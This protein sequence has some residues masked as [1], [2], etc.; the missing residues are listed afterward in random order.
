M[1]ANKLRKRSIFI[2]YSIALVGVNLFT[3]CSGKKEAPKQEIAKVWESN[4]EVM[5]YDFES[6][7]TGNGIEKVKSEYTIVPNGAS[8][9]MELSFY[10]DEKISGI[11]IKPNDSL[12]LDPNK[13]YSL[14]FDAKSLGGK[15][16]FIAVRMANEKGN[17]IRKIVNIHPDALKSYYLEFTVQEQDVASG[18]RDTPKAWK[19]DAIQMKVSGLLYKTSYTKVASIEIYKEQGLHDKKIL[20]DNI[21]IMESPDRD[22]NFLKG[23]VDKYGQNAKMD[24]PIKVSSDE[25]LKR[26]ADE[27]LKSLAEYTLMPDRSQYGG[28]KNGPK[29]KATGFFRKEKVN[30]KW[31]LVDPEGNL[32][33]SIG[34]ANVRMA[35]STTF[36]GIDYTDDSIKH[37]DPEDV[38]PEDSKGIVAIPNAIRKTG[39]VSNKLRNDMFIGL[40]SYDDPLANHYSYR[41]E[42][43]FGP[44][45]HGETFSFYRANLE[46]RYGEQYPNSF[47]DKWLEVTENRM[48]NW[49]FTSFG[50][51]IDPAF[52]DR[53]NLPY[54]ANGWIIGDFQKVYSGVDY[55]GPMPD[56][57]DPEFERRAKKSIDVVS[58]EVKNNP[59][60]I[61]VFVDNERSWGSPSSHRTHYGLV[62][63][64][65]SKDKNSYLK[66]EFMKILRKKHKTIASLNTAWETNIESWEALEKGVD[67]KKGKV[68]GEKMI[69]DFSVLLEAFATK[70]FQVV[71]DALEKKM[72]NHMYLGC[73]FAVWGVTPEVRKSAAKFVDVFSYNYYKEGIGKKYWEFLEEVDMPT[74]IGEYHMGAPDSGLLHSGLIHAK[75]QNDRALMWE[76][77][78]NSVIDNP[79]LVGCHWFQYLDSPLTGR[80][81]DGENYNVG[82]VSTT[83]IPYP[84]MIKKAKEINSGLYTRRFGKEL[85]TKAKQE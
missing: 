3:F 81:H 85:E 7:A 34:L 4:S 44:V 36:T 27:E 42:S 56:P 31:A 59:W 35:N 40:P 5:L 37:R 47:N 46:R 80:A 30:G 26:I 41:R 18:L 43:H 61:G 45:K 2:G 15:S 1:K 55:W 82:F 50:N 68:F 79:Y 8:K 74:L 63:D 52:Y 38:T 78:A 72:P 58:K 9:A 60:C 23:I 28:W 12:T 17:T 33:F 22:P 51:W 53:N 65:L 32:F 13:K 83:D 76:D 70:Y 49:G 25:E 24:F 48:R 21:R 84:P 69:A 57:F 67:Y 11:K 20:L 6:A 29:L 10:K 66:Q 64:G 54:F 75:D 62:L 39:F 71:H 16:T 77:Y 19:T 14:V 73:R